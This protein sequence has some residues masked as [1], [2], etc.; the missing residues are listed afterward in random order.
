MN[1]LNKFLITILAPLT[2]GG[3][4]G[5]LLL[6]CADGADD[7][8]GES[9]ANRMAKSQSEYTTILESQQQGWAVDFYPSDRS[10]GG[11]AYTARFHDGEVAMTCEQ[12]IT[13][14][15]TSTTY[16]V[17]TEISSLY[18][19]VSETGVLLTFDTYN[20]LFHYWS[21]SS[22]GHAKGYNSD[23]EFTFISACADSVIL[24]GKKHGNLMKLYP[25]SEDAATYIKKV[26]QTHTTLSA[27]TR[28]RAII[29][30]TTI[31]VTMSNN[32][33]TFNSGS[34]STTMPFIYTSTGLRF[35][36]Q[37]AINNVSVRE[38]AFN[39]ETLELVSADSRFVMPKPTMTE[40]FLGTSD[41]WYF[42]YNKNSGASD[43]CD[44]LA[45]IVA[46]CAAKVKKPNWGYEVLNAIYLGGNLLNADSD[47]HRMVLGWTSKYG[48]SSNAYFGYAVSMDMADAARNLIS[49]K[50]LEAANGFGDH[51]YCISM[52]DFI[53]QNNPYIL[54]FDNEEAPTSVTLTS[55]RDSSKWFKLTK[56]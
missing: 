55:E 14:S 39:T 45:A 47:P 33:L 17:G 50:P 4:V 13:N 23:Y 2:L 5:G 19:I 41:Q 7:V 56:K 20:P 21:Q 44:E 8:F 30:G 52:V 48:G 36:Q 15:V 40:K 24:R 32:N 22:P 49:I 16:A 29:D 31:A 25:L 28:K 43:M 18:R 54:A 1:R 46:D 9:A 6:S 51:N 12:P 38:L 42:G 53:E 35:Y 26:E 10:Q 27:I 34:S 3:V 11:V 37:V